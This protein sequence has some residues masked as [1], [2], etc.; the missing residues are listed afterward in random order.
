MKQVK[1]E[2][3]KMNIVMVQEQNQVFPALSTHDKFQNLFINYV[4]GIRKYFTC[5]NMH[6]CITHV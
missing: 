6:T 4:I 1:T 5:A 2:Q 3:W